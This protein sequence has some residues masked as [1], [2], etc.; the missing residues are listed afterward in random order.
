[1]GLS[2]G[3][4][5]VGISSSATYAQRGRAGARL[6]PTSRALFLLEHAL[7]GGGEGLL[8]C[9]HELSNLLRVDFAIYPFYTLR[10][11]AAQAANF[12][13]DGDDPESK[14]ISAVYVGR[15]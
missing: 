4:A 9:P 15:F 13:Y 10:N 1:M 2:C 3:G 8:P 12:K 5:V 11:L 7:V 14:H 6:H